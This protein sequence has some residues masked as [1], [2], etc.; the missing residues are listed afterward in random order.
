MHAGPLLRGQPA[1]ANDRGADG[2]ADASLLQPLAV[3]PRRAAARLKS[4]QRE[5]ADSCVIH[6][7]HHRIGIVQR[8]RHGL[9]A[10]DVLAVARRL[11]AERGR[12]NRGTRRHDHVHVVAAYNL[13]VVVGRIRNAEFRGCC[14]QIRRLAVRRRRNYRTLMVGNAPQRPKS[15]VPM[16][17]T[18]DTKTHF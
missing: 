9:H 2:I 10:D 14:F 17:H 7:R 5:E 18:R 4:L 1:T 15:G 13:V 16:V 6:R 11:Q 3:L 12:F 8:Q